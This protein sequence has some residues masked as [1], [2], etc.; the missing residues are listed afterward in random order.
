MAAHGENEA[1]SVVWNV[2][3]SKCE[4]WHI[5]RQVWWPITTMSM[6]ATWWQKIQ[7][8]TRL[9][10]SGRGIET[11]YWILDL[12]VTSQLIHPFFLNPSKHVFHIGP[13]GYIKVMFT[14]LLGLQLIW[15]FQDDNILKIFSYLGWLTTMQLV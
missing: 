4:S 11:N 8:I 3:C 1:M 10:F 7:R 6:V 2:P 13:L 14:T 5:S 12:C 9:A 15:N